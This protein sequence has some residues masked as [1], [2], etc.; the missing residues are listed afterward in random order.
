MRLNLS[1]EIVLNKIPEEYYNPKTAVE[2]SEIT[3]C[4]KIHTDIFPKI[5]EGA[6]YIARAIETE[7]KFKNDQGK[8][9]VLGLGTGNSLTPVYE[10]LIRL[11]KE[12]GLSFARVAVFNAYEYFPLNEGN[13]HSSISQLRER[14]LDHVNIAPENVFT[15][16]GTVPQEMV[17]SS[18][19]QYEQRIVDMGG[20]DV[21]LLGI[22]RMGNIATNEPGSVLTSGSRLILIDAVS[23]EEMTLSFGS[24]EAVPPCSITMGIAT[25]LSARKIFLTAWGEDK[26]DIIQRA[27]EEKVTDVLP[28]SF[29]QTHKDAN[30]V[31]DLPA[32]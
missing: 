23:R 32:A 16:D 31:K 15:L 25:I 18:C 12:N 29:L 9:C 24:K 7:I 28:A 1:S 21:M 13:P 19:K 6:T 4:E 30:V 27:V 17:N 5:E 20:I 3:R 10:E 2:R 14:F 8:L 11:H 26:A 22:G